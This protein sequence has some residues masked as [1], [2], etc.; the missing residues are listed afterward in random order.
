MS[1]A[2]RGDDLLKP[3]EKTLLELIERAKREAEAE[4][5]RGVKDG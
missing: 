2:R 5:R 4:K 3:W 1:K